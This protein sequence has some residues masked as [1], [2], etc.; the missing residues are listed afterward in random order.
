MYVQYLPLQ[1]EQKLNIWKALD[2]TQAETLYMNSEIKS[3]KE[4]IIINE[5]HGIVDNS[6]MKVKE[7]QLCSVLSA[8]L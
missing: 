3:W 2:S 6:P 1:T 8:Y 7:T 5:E 4:Q